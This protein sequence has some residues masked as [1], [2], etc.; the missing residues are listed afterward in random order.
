VTDGAILAALLVTPGARAL[1]DLAGGSIAVSAFAL[2]VLLGA[3]TFPLS[4]YRSFVLER[5]YELSRITAAAWLRDY[6]KSAAV[7]LAAGV[8]GFTV[9]YLLLDAFPR[10]WWLP[11]A[12]AGA[13]IVAMSTVAAPVLI[14]PRFNRLS[15]LE[16]DGLRERLAALSARAGMPVPGV[17]EWRIGGKSRRASAALVGA[18]LTRRILVSDTLLADYS[19]DEIE[20]VLAHEIGHHVHRDVMKGLWAEFLLMAACCLAA[21]V[22]LN[23]LWKPLGLWSPSD[24]AGAPLLLLAAG[25]VALAA[26][27]LLNALSR[28]NE[29]RADEYALD[30]C[31]RP[32]AFISA[33]RRMAAQNLAD[34]S[35]SRTA[36]LMFHTHPLVE[37]RIARARRRSRVRQA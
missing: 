19:D 13:G 8:P 15:P 11:A 29:R 33:M 10:W 26:T 31:S 25:A 35:P 37:D 34:E 17:H 22:A 2:L 21:A 7:L 28:R 16:R 4:W 3:A 14:L 36:F 27:P 9:I 30:L 6:F 5:Q 1:R 32:D 18:G 12:A 20:V 23:V 24:P